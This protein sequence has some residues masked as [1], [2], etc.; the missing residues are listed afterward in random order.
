M[1]GQRLF[2]RAIDQADHDAIGPFL[3][4]HRGRNDIPACGLLGKLAGQ[5]VAVLEMH[6]TPEAIQITDIVV[7]R[8]LRRIRIGRGMLDEVDQI[9]S[10]IERPRLVVETMTEGQEFF[11][12]V[13]FEWEGARWIRN[14]RR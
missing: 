10:R 4:E 5:L 7:A 14:V 11:R 12:H 3:R 6:I 9:A 8:E 13:G 1:K 2:I